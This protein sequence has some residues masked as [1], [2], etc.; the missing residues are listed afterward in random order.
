MK[1]LA[2][3]DRYRVPWPESYL[4]LLKLTKEQLDPKFN[5]AFI[6]TDDGL[7]LK[8]L[9]SA[10]G[11]W[12][13]VSVSCRDRCPTWTEMEYAKRLFF[14]DDETA[15]QLHVPPAKHINR[16][17]FCLHIWRPRGL[18]KIPMPPANMA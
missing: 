10:G 5:G 1:D 3:L 7:E 14:K 13:H 18:R 12:D 15:M 8:I 16:H 4:K 11:G 2:L 6:I 17:P 9:A